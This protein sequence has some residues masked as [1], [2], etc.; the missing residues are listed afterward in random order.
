MNL[1]WSSFYIDLVESFFEH[2]LLG[3]PEGLQVHFDVSAESFVAFQ[4]DMVALLSHLAILVL[5]SSA[6]KSN[7]L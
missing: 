1:S 7:R 4:D 5:E 3:N 2:F 6:R